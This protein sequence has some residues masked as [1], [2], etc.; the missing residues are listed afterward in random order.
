MKISAGECRFVQGKDG[1][2]D[3]NLV[4][5]R[6]LERSRGDAWWHMEIAKALGPRPALLTKEG[7]RKTER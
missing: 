1:N 2:L 6:C 4:Y 5:L 3:L 7:G